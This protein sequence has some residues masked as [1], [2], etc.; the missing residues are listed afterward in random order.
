MITIGISFAATARAVSAY[1]QSALNRLDGTP[2][3]VLLSVPR[4]VAKIDT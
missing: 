3:S 2:P 1:L 4:N